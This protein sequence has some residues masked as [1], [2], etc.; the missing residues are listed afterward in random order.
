MPRLIWGAGESRGLWPVLIELLLMLAIPRPE[1][2]I[3]RRVDRLN[4][5]PV[6]A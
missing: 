5:Y 3:I 2:L 4:S 6:G 1:P